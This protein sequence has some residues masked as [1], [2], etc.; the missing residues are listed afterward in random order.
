METLLKS[1]EK[2][3]LASEK[4]VLKETE[5]IV[6]KQVEKLSKRISNLQT[7]VKAVEKKGKQTT[8]KKK[9]CKTPD[10]ILKPFEKRFIV[11][12]FIENE[13]LVTYF[14]KKIPNSDYSARIIRYG[15]MNKFVSML[16]LSKQDAN[17]HLVGERL[18]V[19][20]S[21]TIFGKKSC[22]WNLKKR[23]EFFEE[24]VQEL[25]VVYTQFCEALF[26]DIEGYESRFLPVLLELQETGEDVYKQ[27]CKQMR[28]ILLNYVNKIKPI[29]GENR[30]NF[31]S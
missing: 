12:D 5:T 27:H 31:Q 7:R 15:E 29:A 10:F 13:V 8:V 25:L 6:K 17:I 16:F 2:L 21:V 11:D 18:Y 22:G 24:L 28:E 3:I 30:K 23:K 1:I 14:R 9:A 19:Y 20:E 26:E 4:R